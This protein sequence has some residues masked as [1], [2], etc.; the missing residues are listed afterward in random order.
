VY[1]PLLRARLPAS[2]LSRCVSYQQ[3]MH[4]RPTCAGRSVSPPPLISL[5]YSLLFLIPPF[6][7]ASCSPP[8]SLLTARCE[9]SLPSLHAGG[10]FA[11]PFSPLLRMIC[12]TCVFEFAV[13]F[14]A[15][16]EFQSL[17]RELPQ[18]SALHVALASISDM[19]HVQAR[20][21]GEEQATISIWRIII[22]KQLCEAS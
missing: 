22:G 3:L 13:R 7:L 9:S 1:C 15:G 19:V 4:P 10:L 5:V 8:P 16:E 21:R 17:V 14:A 11:P 12:R 18:Q 6:G 2:P 20:R